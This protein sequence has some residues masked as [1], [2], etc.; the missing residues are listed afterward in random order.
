MRFFTQQLHDTADDELGQRW[1][2]GCGEF[3]F[4]CECGTI[5]L[6]RKLMLRLKRPR[7][8]VD[9]QYGPSPAYLDSHDEFRC[10]YCTQTWRDCDCTVPAP[11]AARQEPDTS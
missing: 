5:S 3:V 9:A 1:C 11:F 4:N 7:V 2:L 10:T 6:G 8:D